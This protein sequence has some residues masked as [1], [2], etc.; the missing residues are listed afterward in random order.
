MSTVK[1][2]KKYMCIIKPSDVS[3]FEEGISYEGYDARKNYLSLKGYNNFEYFR[4][5]KYF[6][7]DPEYE[8]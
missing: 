6:V 1:T 3:L 2:F 7:V 8:E 4:N 5:K